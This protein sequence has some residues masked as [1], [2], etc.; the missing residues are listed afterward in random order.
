MKICQSLKS[1]WTIIQNVPTHWRVNLVDR[2]Q[3]SN[4]REC[5]L[6]YLNDGIQNKEKG[7]QRKRVQFDIDSNLIQKLINT[8]ESL[9]AS[10]IC[11]ISPCEHNRRG[12]VCDFKL[13]N[14]SDHRL[15]SLEIRT[16]YVRSLG[17]GGPD[18]SIHFFEQRR[19]KNCLLKNISHR[20]YE[21]E[22]IK[23]SKCVK[24]TL[25][26]NPLPLESV[27]TM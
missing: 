7:S 21:T 16:Q 23:T 26:S 25:S 27:V 6:I 9:H 14:R 5:I 4:R 3:R 2:I 8:N 22:G 11:F 13:H 18:K 12:F 17:R 10:L 19:F 1:G 15:L 24:C 20:M